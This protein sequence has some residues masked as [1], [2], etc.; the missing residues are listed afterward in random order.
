MIKNTIRAVAVA[1]AHP[2]VADAIHRNSS[3]ISL[4]C[5]KYL[6]KNHSGALHRGDF[7]SFTV[8]NESEG[9]WG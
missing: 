4:L 6:F 9:D 3:F 2:A 8:F 1:I 7:L 5:K